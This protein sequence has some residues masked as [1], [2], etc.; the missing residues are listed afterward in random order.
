M[1]ATLLDR[2]DARDRALF[3]RCAIDPDSRCIRWLWVMLTHIGGAT[4][5]VAA[6]IAPRIL[7]AAG[8]L[9]RASS[10]ALET[11]VLSHLVVQLVKRT[12]GRPRPSR[13]ILRASAVREPDQFSFPSG[14][15]AAA[16]SVAFVY[17]LC[18]PSFAAPL[19]TIAFV[20][21]L[22]RVCLGVHYPG[23]VVVGQ[24]L[25]VLTGVL[26]RAIS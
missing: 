5:S 22:S 15:S 25:A 24:A 9:A 21:G 13:A 16:M 17:A 4:C 2:L 20:V 6:A 19:L 12:V 14:H 10:Q 18:F 11:L 7:G 23:D 3:T 26:V 8:E 1:T